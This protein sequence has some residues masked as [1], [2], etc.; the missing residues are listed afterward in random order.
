MDLLTAIG[1]QERSLTM[2]SLRAR[3]EGSGPDPLLV[4]RRAAELELGAAD[5][6]NG[7]K[8]AYVRRGY[9]EAAN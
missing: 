5:A 7:E 2:M 1:S 3:E 4:C 6:A 8:K 9:R